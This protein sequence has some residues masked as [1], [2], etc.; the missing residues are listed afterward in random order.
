MGRRVSLRKLHQGVH[1]KPRPEGSRSREGRKQDVQIPIQQDRTWNI[2]GTESAPACQQC[3]G[4][5]G[6][7][8]ERRQSGGEAT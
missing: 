5:E 6:G 4:Q 3:C 7:W 2:R 1:F 8:W